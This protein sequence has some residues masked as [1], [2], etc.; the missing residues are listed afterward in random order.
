MDLFPPFYTA[1]NTIGTVYPL[2]Y[3]NFKSKP[4]SITHTFILLMAILYT[5]II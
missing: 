3:E 1:R 5:T 2:D 4:G